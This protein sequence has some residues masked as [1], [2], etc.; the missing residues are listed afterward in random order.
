MSSFFYFDSLAVF[1][2]KFEVIYERPQTFV[3]C[4]KRL[5]FS[6]Q[7]GDKLSRPSHFF[8]L[9]NIASSRKINYLSLVLVVLKLDDTFLVL[10]IVYYTT[11][12]P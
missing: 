9:G 3:D 7:F 5:S 12:Y 10:V 11:F 6:Q 1:N 8:V 4:V 2:N